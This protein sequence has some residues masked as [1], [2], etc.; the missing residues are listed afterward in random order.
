MLISSWNNFVLRARWQ[1]QNVIVGPVAVSLP[2]DVGGESLES[3]SF[4][5]LRLLWSARAVDCVNWTPPGQSPARPAAVSVPIWSTEVSGAWPRD[6]GENN[7]IIGVVVGRCRRP[8][9]KFDEGPTRP[10]PV[11][12]APARRRSIGAGYRDPARPSRL[13]GRS[14][15][16]RSLVKSTRSTTSSGRP[17]A[18]TSARLPMLM[19][20]PVSRLADA[21]SWPDICPQLRYLPPVTY[22]S[23]E[24]HYRGHLRWYAPGCC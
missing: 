14:A 7:V 4:A 15:T 13:V 6:A 9:T 11:P 18:T 23:S 12:R 20:E 8:P 3:F 1:R 10:R 21:L 16:L 24:N 19:P 22:F 17:A 5:Y 2:A